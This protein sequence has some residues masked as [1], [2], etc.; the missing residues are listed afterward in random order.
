MVNVCVR[1]V[2]VLLAGLAAGCGAMTSGRADEEVGVLRE[3]I[4]RDLKNTS[5]RELNRLQVA[6]RRLDPSR[7]DGGQPGIQCPRYVWSAGSADQTPVLLVMDTDRFEMHPGSTAISLTAFDADGG[8]RARGQINI[9]WRTYLKQ[10]RLEPFADGA[11]PA[12]A[13]ECVLN[14]GPDT[15]FFYLARVGDR[16]DLVRAAPPGKPAWRNGYHARHFTRGTPPP[17]QDA[18]AWEADLG[19]G[20]R[21]RVLRALVWLGGYHS[22]IREGEPAHPSHETAAEANLARAVRARPGVIAKLQA[23]GKSGDEWVKE[24][25]HQAA[26][27]EDDK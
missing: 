2:S 15:I 23:L 26:S 17:V 9:G 27:P 12:I 3:Y 19:S 7:P 21:A 8:V 18:D 4:G 25:A 22:T 10:A 5:E 11:E 20:D 1:L 14:H 6:L 16:F 24:A 13:L